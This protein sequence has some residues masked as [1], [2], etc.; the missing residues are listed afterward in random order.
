MSGRSPIRLRLVLASII[1]TTAVMIAA[2]PASANGLSLIFPD[3]VSPN[4]HNIYDLYVLITWPAAVIFVGVEAALLY[5]IIRFRRKHPEQVGASWH[6]NT[7]VEIV[8][9]I[10]PTIIV[11]AIAVAAFVELQRDFTV[12]AANNHADMNVAVR[13]YQFEWRYTYDEGFTTTNTMVVPVGKMVHMTFD[14]DNVIH[15]WWVPALTGKTDAVPGYQNQSWIK[16]EPS[17]LDNCGGN[18]R[19]VDKATGG[20]SFHGECAELCG[21]G[22][23]VMQIDVI[24]VTPDRYATWVKEQ[25]VKASAP[26]ATPKPS[27]SP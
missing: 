5:I 26:K 8:W 18:D 22:H 15:S 21:A 11:G 25:K 17:A 2:V 27:P 3:P 10:I 12:E 14:S 20:C 9:T 1:A 19:Q 13:G 16:I 7:M 23:S 24:A 6:G 4:G